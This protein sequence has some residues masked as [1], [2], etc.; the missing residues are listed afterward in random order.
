MEYEY[1][2]MF[3]DRSIKIDRVPQKGSDYEEKQYK[4]K[5]SRDHHYQE[6]RVYPP[7]DIK[8][9]ETKPHY[10]PD[11]EESSHRPQ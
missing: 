4:A 5:Y 11:R 10:R 1:H 8:R 9:D 7:R 6:K 3:K 2:E